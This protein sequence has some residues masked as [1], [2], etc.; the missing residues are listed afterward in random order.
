MDS[1]LN[2]K[3]EWVKAEEI[4][5]LGTTYKIYKDIDLGIDKVSKTDFLKKEIYI[6]ND[7]TQ[8]LDIVFRREIM[9]AFFYETG[10]MKYAYDD[11]LVD[12]LAKQFE[13]IK[14]SDRE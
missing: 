11:I 2:E 3:G 14:I 13:K 1:R 8:K 10:L 6:T 12:F 9:R 7:P 5:I 4:D